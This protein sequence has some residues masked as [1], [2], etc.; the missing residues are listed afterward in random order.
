MLPGIFSL[1][2]MMGAAWA[3]ESL[4]FGGFWALCTWFNSN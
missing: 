3:Y 2:V 4:N 1:G